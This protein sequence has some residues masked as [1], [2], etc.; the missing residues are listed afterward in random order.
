[1]SKLSSNSTCY[2]ESNDKGMLI[3]DMT[4]SVS[5]DIRHCIGI[6]ETV[7]RDIIISRHN[8][9]RDIGLYEKSFN[10]YNSESSSNIC[11]WKNAYYVSV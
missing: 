3:N 1:M 2:I 11:P 6:F 10:D 9:T 4:K 8:L 5:F 7:T